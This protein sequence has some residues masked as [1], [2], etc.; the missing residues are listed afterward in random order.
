[1]EKQRFISIFHYHQVVMMASIS[2]LE[3]KIS[4]EERMEIIRRA[5]GHDIE[6]LLQNT[7]YALVL[8]ASPEKEERELGSELASHAI[9][10]NNVVAIGTR[11]IKS[12]ANDKVYVRSY[13]SRDIKKD[14]SSI[15]GALESTEYMIS[16]EYN[17]KISFGTEP[18]LLMQAV[19]NAVKNSKNAIRSYRH[20]KSSEVRSNIHISID[21]Y[22][23]QEQGEIKD[24]LRRSEDTPIEGQFVRIAICDGGPGFSI[25]TEES[26]NLGRSGEAGSG[27]GLYLVD[28]VRETLRGHL[29]IHSE[30]GNTKVEMYFPI[31]YTEQ[32][33]PIVDSN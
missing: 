3:H 28:K 26:L 31:G 16:F 5:T 18:Y 30:P 6:S 8:S 27:F 21:Y 25:D 14:L 4:I 24:I 20:K 2:E 17:P 12:W 23:T 19:F 33:K 13:D 9:D 11:A 15:K 32:G 7:S 1:M 22:D 10:N 29:A